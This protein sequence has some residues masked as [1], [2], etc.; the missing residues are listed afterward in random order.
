MYGGIRK[1]GDAQE[2]MINYKFI[3]EFNNV[4]IKKL[5]FD[6]YCKLL[7]ARF[8]NLIKLLNSEMDSNSELKKTVVLVNNMVIQLNKV[9]IEDR[10]VVNSN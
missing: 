6:K 10:S 7:N 1:L 2:L 3:D 5:A 4:I 8:G 9:F